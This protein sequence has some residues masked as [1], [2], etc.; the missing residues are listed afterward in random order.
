[1]HLFELFKKLRQKKYFTENQK[2]ETFLRAKIRTANN[3]H[4]YIYVIFM[5]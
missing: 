1:M 3:F 4:I 2:L 5:I